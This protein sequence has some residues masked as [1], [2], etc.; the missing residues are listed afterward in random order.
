M[1]ESFSVEEI[2]KVV[3]NSYDGP[4]EVEYLDNPRVEQTEHHYNVVHTGL[5]E[6]GLQP[7]LLSNTLI[8]S[9]FRVARAHKD[10]VDLGAMRPAVQWRE[11]TSPLRVNS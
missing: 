1:T 11:A 6:L 3:A 10:R 8:E 7:H 4:V 5:V 9:L 2:A